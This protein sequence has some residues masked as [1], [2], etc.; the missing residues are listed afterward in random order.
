M[1]EPSTPTL[2]TDSHYNR[3]WLSLVAFSLAL[4]LT[5]VAIGDSEIRRGFGYT[6]SSYFFWVGVFLIFVPTALRLLVK[7]VDRR[8]RLTLVVLL[9][10]SL[11]LVKYL[12]S[13]SAFTFV[14][15]YIH[16]RNTQDILRTHHLFAY[17]PLLTTAAYYPGLAAVTAGLVN[18]TGLSI[19]VSGLIVIGVVRALFTACFFL[20]AERVTKSDRAAAGACLVYVANPM[21]LFWSADFSYENLTLFLAAFT[22]WWLGRTRRAKGNAPLV[23]A[24]VAIAAITVTHH[25]VGFALS[26]LLG[27][28]WIVERFTQR[29][30][31]A[32]RNV[33]LMALLSTT[34]TLIWFFIVARPA[35]AYLFT[36]NIFPALRQTVSL[37]LG[38]ISPRHLYT[39]GGL[40]SPEWEKIAGF[41]AIGVLLLALLPGLYL[42]WRHRDRAPIVVA[43]GVAILF[44]LSLVPRLAP[45]GV[46]ISGRSSEYVFA[47]LGCV[48]GLLVTDE[49]WRRHREHA[50][51]MNRDG[52]AAWKKVTVATA[53]VAL[54]FIGE[55]SVGTPFY[56][57]LPEAPHPHGY[58][59]LVQPDAI[60][61][62]NWAR[63]HLGTNQRF[64]ADS[65]DSLAL[66]TYGQQNTVAE[67]KVWPIF[68]SKT[69]NKTVIR[70][71]KSDKIHYL[72]VDWE[73]TKGVPPD[74][75]FY[76][77]IKEPGA[78]DYKN[79]FLPAALK[80][81]DSSTC[82][83]LVYHHKEIQ[84]FD[85][86]R[87]RN[88]FCVPVPKSSVKDD[89]IHG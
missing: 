69:M 23:V 6:E 56:E 33:G 75:G 66:D 48:L 44:P 29:P 12:G 16:V 81:F 62:S 41:A 24:I 74:P 51:V 9:G 4:G 72:F 5:S 32:R 45:E 71:I 55:I 61:A 70:A 11:Y 85:V 83:H 57:L 15:E 13:P 54:V 20:I 43:I 67:V 19:F 79:A 47:G 52:R 53:L 73:M 38:R 68:F 46:G 42:A 28:W 37:V 17:N 27:T 7:N 10:I 21:F 22:I 65:L 78:Q 25:V 80:K 59:W 1:N 30:S 31:R 35:P 76:F 8:E 3:L 34:T 89:G 87:I 63:E 64:A 58:P 50:R 40:V 39:S 49:K 84:I 14:D 26:A 2:P 88:G 86:S 60:S 82:V 77:S 36:D 18:L